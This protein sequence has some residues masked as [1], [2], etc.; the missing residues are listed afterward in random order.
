MRKIGKEEKRREERGKRREGE[1]G[2]EIE[3]GRSIAF[4]GK[5]L[6]YSDGHAHEMHLV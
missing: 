2:R 1:G 3:R 6:G 5:R 4:V